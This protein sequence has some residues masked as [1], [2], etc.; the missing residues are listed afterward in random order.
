MNSMG[1]SRSVHGLL[2]PL[3]RYRSV[4]LVSVAERMDLF[5]R[6]TRMPMSAATEATIYGL[7]FSG[8]RLFSQ[9]MELASACPSLF[10]MRY[11]A[12]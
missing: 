5:E 1:T 9:R 3:W 4:M 6:A 8:G 2:V 12:S 7:R 11:A 10:R